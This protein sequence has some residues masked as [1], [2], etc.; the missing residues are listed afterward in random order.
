LLT[1]IPD[2][3]SVSA[4]EMLTPAVAWRPEIHPFPGPMMCGNSIGYFTP[5]TRAVDY[6]LFEME[7]APSGVE[8]SSTLMAWGFVLERR[9]AGI[10][11]WRLDSNNVAAEDCPSWEQQKRATLGD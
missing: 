11:L 9:A 6:V 8:W 4:T 2:F 7:N 5:R 3:A 10:E 1:E